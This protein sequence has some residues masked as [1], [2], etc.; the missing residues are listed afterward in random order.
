M[1]KGESLVP[2][3]EKNKVNLSVTF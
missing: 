1:E 3:N 2:H